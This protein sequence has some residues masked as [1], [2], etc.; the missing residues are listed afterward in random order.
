MKKR[1]LSMIIVLC[2]AVGLVPAQA[3]SEYADSE[4]YSLQFKVDY[5]A[6]ISC[7]VPTEFRIEVLNARE[8]YVYKYRMDTPVYNSGGGAYSIADPTRWQYKDFQTGDPAFKFQFMASGEYSIYFYVMEF[9]ADGKVTSGYNRTVVNL[10]IDDANYPS[11]DSISDQVANQCLQSCPGDYE[12]ALWLHDW[13]MSKCEYDYSLTY[14][15]AEGVFARGKGT[16]ESY[17]RAYCLLL[18]KV[19]IANARVEGNGHVWTAARL[20]GSWYQIDVT[21]DD[22]NY[23]DKHL[24]FG[25]NDELMSIAHSDHQ[26]NSGC[27]S[28]SLEKNY[29]IVSGGVSRWSDAFKDEIV[30][31]LAA[32]TLAFSI[33][34]PEKQPESVNGII[35]G[36]AAYDLS[37]REWTANGKKYSLE[38]DYTQNTMSFT[39][40]EKT[41][42]EPIV[43][44]EEKSYSLDEIAGR[45][46]GKTLT[47]CVD[48]RD[49]YP[50][51]NGSFGSIELSEGGKKLITAAEYNL[52]FGSDVHK[53][54]P[55]AMYVYSLSNNG[56]YSLERLSGLDNLLSYGGSSIRISGNKGIRM[57][58]GIESSAK[59]ALIGG[60]V[61]GYKLEEYG[62][63]L[64]WASEIKNSSL[65]LSDSYARHNY[66]YSRAAGADPVFRVSG[67]KVQYTNVLV[68]FSNAQCVDD[69]SMRSYIKLTGPDGKQVTLYGGVVSRS[70]GYIAYQNR[71][72]FA[73]GTAAY[74]YIWDIIH[75]VYG[76]KY[77]A[78]Y[79]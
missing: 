8:G 45:H 28:S 34:T 35:Y 70:I 3:F 23:Y 61:S 21:W 66:A 53:M 20:D 55:T 42:T 14:C 58:T 27:P 77:D 74:N 12:K 26:A 13:I 22:D 56:G 30:S 43:P 37:S 79:K 41:G 32:G 5:P 67:S 71:G 51:S 49:Y 64:C 24:Y 44:P 39:A 48:G 19:G 52:P 50:D 73:P 1:L 40:K 31:Q 17:H 36:I 38:A 6:S 16:C 4:T 2:I 54:Y 76:N 7:G 33:E 47:L 68:G 59:S 46:G 18:D 57:I 72:A 62:T 63:L 75:Y 15:N 11:V 29:Y 69:I 10:I 78:D 60:G 9:D 25:L 65:S